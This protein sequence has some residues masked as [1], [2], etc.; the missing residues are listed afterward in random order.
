ME[1]AHLTPPEPKREAPHSSRERILDAAEMLVAER[2]YAAASISLIAKV[3][4]LPSSSIYW[5]FES[6]EDLLAA[7]VERGARR[8]L[9]AQPKWPSFKGDFSKF[10]QA[11]G[12]AAEKHPAFVRILM[13]I[14]LDRSEGAPRAR[15]M[16]SNLWRD[17]ESSFEHIITSHFH[18]GRDEAGHRTAARLA[19]FLM[20]F[21]DGAFVDSHIDP[22]GM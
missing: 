8:W 4:G 7:V 19:R 9:E 13:M 1:K 14:M 17:V 10:L 5:H 15:M 12:K 11:T 2:G 6:K 20:A 22:K 3:S 16:M 18:L 21:L